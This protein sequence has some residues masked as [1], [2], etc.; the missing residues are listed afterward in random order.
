LC[1]LFVQL[2]FFFIATYAFIKGRNWIRPFVLV[3]G[4]CVATSVW[5]IMG[6]LYHTA[7]PGTLQ[8][9]AILIGVYSIWFFIPLLLIIRMWNDH[10]FGVSHETDGKKKK[11]INK[12]LIK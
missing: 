1:S 8:N 5:S 9:K 11:K 6:E 2:P 12:K 7:N 10:P 3:Y 4:S